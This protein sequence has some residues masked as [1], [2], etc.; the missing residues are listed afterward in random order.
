MQVVQLTHSLKIKTLLFAG[1]I[2]LSNLP[3]FPHLDIHQT[4]PAAM[5]LDE[6]MKEAEKNLNSKLIKVLQSLK[7]SNP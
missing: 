7:K 1:K 4:T 5:N 2:S 6:A 3:A